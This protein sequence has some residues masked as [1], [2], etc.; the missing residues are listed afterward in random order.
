MVECKQSYRSLIIAMIPAMLS[1]TTTYGH[2]ILEPHIKARGRVF[3]TEQQ[4]YGA[5]KKNP[6]A[7]AP[8]CYVAPWEGVILSYFCKKKLTASSI[9]KNLPNANGGFSVCAQGD[10]HKLVDVFKAVGIRYLFS[11]HIHPQFES[12]A[13]KMIPILHYPLR[14]VAPAQKKDILYSFIGFRS[15]VFRN[16]VYALGKKQRDVIIKKRSSF[17]GTRAKNSKNKQGK[18]YDNVLARSRYSL[19]PRGHFPNSIRLTESLF[20]GAIPVILADDIRL[21]EGI[22][23]EECCVFIRERNVGHI[24]K[25]LRNIPIEEEEELRTR[26]LEVAEIIRKDPAYF[27][28]YYFGSRMVKPKVSISDNTVTVTASLVTQ[29]P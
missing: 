9:G 1:S 14:T 23:W 28:R 16:K 3:V 17:C 15:H 8:T 13:F 18:E 6:I 26:C 5:I 7:G 20:A 2:N 25:I 11:P 22:N 24:D 29:Y 12:R 27:I 19:C 21:P 4:V 10:Y